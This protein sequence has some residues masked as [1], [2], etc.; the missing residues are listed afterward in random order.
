MPFQKACKEFGQEKV[1][2]EIIRSLV[3]NYTAITAVTSACIAARVR[4]ATK[5]TTTAITAVDT[6]LL[7]SIINDKSIHLDGLYILLSND[8]IATLSMLKQHLSIV[9]EGQPAPTSTL[10]T[11]ATM[12]VSPTTNSN[13]NMR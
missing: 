6:S 5:T 3:E 2:T 11:K 1:I 4:S 7:M 12:A 13:K 8:H 9:E 10:E